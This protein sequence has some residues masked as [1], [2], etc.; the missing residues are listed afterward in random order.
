MKKKFFSLALSGVLLCSVAAPALAAGDMLISPGPEAGDTEPLTRAGLV[1]L[2]HTAEG[3]PVVNYLMDYSDVDQSAPYGEAV[4]WAASEQLV[5]GYGDGSFG[6]ENAVTR[7]Q[8]VSILWRW[9]GSP[10][11]MDY[12]GL[13]NYSDAGDISLFAQPALAWAHQKGLFPQE[14]RLGPKDIVSSEEAEAILSALRA[15][16][17]PLEK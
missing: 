10:M 2:L 13:T 16:R 15:E 11:L 17:L 9:A 14:G 4:R 6:P 12:P 7:E 1:S 5:S 3:G 8:M